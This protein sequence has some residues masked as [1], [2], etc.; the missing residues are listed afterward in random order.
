MADKKYYWL[1][2]DRNFFKRH[3]IKII[4]SMEN[5]KDYVLFYLKLLLESIDHEGELRF[6]D[7]IPYNEKMLSTITD[8]NI[9]IV[10]SAI[11]LF[12]EL[13]MMQLY[14]DGTLYLSEITK[15]IGCETSAAERVRKHRDK[16]TLHCN[17]MLQKCNTEKE[18]EKEIEIEIDKDI[19]V[20]FKDFSDM[21]VKIKKPLTDKA[22]SMILKKLEELSNGDIKKSIEILDQSTVN[23]WKSV[24]ELKESKRDIL[25]E[26]IQEGENGKSRNGQNY[27]DYS[28]PIQKLLQG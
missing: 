28:K 23:C 19:L 16:K 7:T 4:E 21:R 20:A 9:D 6:N 5:G 8:T 22:S 17:K 24:Y 10:R 3:D 27:E 1:K 26:I 2:L 25:M 13:N 18:T 11:K 12:K 15:M 14:D